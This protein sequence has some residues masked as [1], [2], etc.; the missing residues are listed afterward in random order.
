MKTFALAPK[1][2]NESAATLARDVA[3]WLSDRGYPVAVPERLKSSINFAGV[4]YVADYDLCKAGDIVIGMGG[5][6]TM[7]YLANKATT[8]NEFLGVNFGHYGFITEVG[9][10]EVFRALES[11]TSGTYVKSH[12]GRVLAFTGDFGFTGMNEISITRK[13]GRMEPLVVAINGE[14]LG[15]LCS[16][17]I[18]V[19]T[20]TGSTGY[21][22]AAGGPLVHPDMRCLVV[23]PICPH[24]MN[25]RPIIIPETHEVE[26]RSLGHSS[27]VADADPLRTVELKPGAR[28][29]IKHTTVTIPFIQETE[30]SFYTKLRERMRWGERL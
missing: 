6:G 25:S 27:M 2:E 24:T 5:D 14:S 15:K 17:G 19:S 29:E 28:V 1:P 30:N 23:T 7:L 13:W 20:P 16:D 11:I 3:H 22:L 26:V 18:I 10:A 4:T 12:R 8:V 21:S 9:P